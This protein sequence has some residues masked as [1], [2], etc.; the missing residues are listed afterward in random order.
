MDAFELSKTALQR[1]KSGAT[2]LA[3]MDLSDRIKW[4]GIA[5]K[6]GKSN[7]WLLQRLHG[8]EVNGKP[9]KMKESE[10]ESFVSELRKLAE[11]VNQ[12]ADAIE[13]ASLKD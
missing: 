11:Q 8:Y 6:M 3:L 9:A 7:N 10:Y 1:T 12:A 13:N 2:W 5:Q 4:A